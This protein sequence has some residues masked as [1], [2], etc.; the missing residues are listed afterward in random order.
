VVKAVRVASAD[1]TVRAELV[2]IRAE[3]VMADA[4]A[5]ADVMV[6]V[7]LVRALADKAADPARIPSAVMQL[8][9]RISKRSARRTREGSLRKRISA[10]RRIICMRRTRL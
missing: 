5:S 1:A 4:V 6:R 7:D 2:S 3:V 9:Q 10:T 8:P